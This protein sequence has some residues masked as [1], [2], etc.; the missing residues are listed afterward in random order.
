[1]FDGL[2]NSGWPVLLTI[3]VAVMCA[4][5]GCREILVSRR[6]ELR[7]LWPT[8]WFLTA[9]LLAVMA[10]GQASDIGNFISD[11]GRREAQS[12]D[13]YE[14]RRSAQTVIVSL[15]AAVWAIVVLVAI[16]RVPE[17]RRR[18]L[19]MAIIVFTL[20][21][22]GAIRV[23][24]LHHIDAVVYRRHLGSVQIGRVIEYFLLTLAFVV[25]AAHLRVVRAADE[26]RVGTP[27][28]TS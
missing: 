15:V 7:Y 19:P 13:W 4:V 17:R 21:C 5:V 23:V 14:N 9:V 10:I 24:S 3:A 16:W 11:L 27:I 26:N 6:A 2:N 1:M 20:V 18:Y 8:F 12:Y 28:T 22:F 25:A